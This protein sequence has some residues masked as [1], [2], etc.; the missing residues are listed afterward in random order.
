M[1]TFFFAFFQETKDGKSYDKLGYHDLNLSSFPG[2]GL[3]NCRC[4]LEGYESRHHRQDNSLLHFKVDMKLL[5]GDPCGFKTYAIP[6]EIS[7]Q[8]LILSFTQCLQAQ[9]QLLNRESQ[10][11]LE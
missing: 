3:T 2:A 4:L 11:R 1:L 10:T 7:I 9:F 6:P 8:F 5:A